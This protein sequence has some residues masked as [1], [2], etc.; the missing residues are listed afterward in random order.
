VLDFEATGLD[1]AR[2][3]VISYGFLPVDGGRIRLEGA[4]YRVV[5]PPIPVTAES[6]RVHGLTPGDLTEGPR[7]VD[8]ADELVHALERRTLVAHAA[9]IELGFLGRL[10]R[11]L[12]RRPPRRAIDVL[13]LA[14]R[15]REYGPLPS[16]RL[17]DLAGR[18]G[19]PVARTHHAF[20]D[21]LTT[22]QL[23]LVLA[24]R[25]DAQGEGRLPER[26]RS[27]WPQFARSFVRGTLERG[28]AVA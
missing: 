3:H 4:L 11:Q 25:L 16:P 23:F 27:R 24:T 5:R 8:V 18:Y 1:L 2:D 9:W 14:A 26:R 10:F 19:I 15:D 6:I 13:D 7:L 20:A 12:G 17:A 22:A 28:H 21:C